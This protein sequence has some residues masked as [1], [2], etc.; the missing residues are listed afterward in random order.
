M[1]LLR[2]LIALS[3]IVV[4]MRTH[5]QEQTQLPMPEVPLTPEAAAFAKYGDVP[6]NHST[7]AVNFEVPIY[8]LRLKDFTVP[9]SLSYRSSGF[10]VDEMATDVGLGWTLQG[11]GLIS[12]S[13]RGFRDRYDGTSGY[14]TRDEI[15]ALLDAD[16]LTEMGNLYR[17]CE[18]GACS[19]QTMA[20]INQKPENQDAILL[21]SVD[22]EPDIFHFNFP[23]RNGTF[24]IDKNGDFITLEASRLHI[25]WTGNAFTVIDEVGI[26]YSFN[27]REVLKN[28]NTCNN[29]NVLDVDRG[30]EEDY[31]PNYYLTSICLPQGGCIYYEYQDYSYV[32]YNGITQTDYF[33]TSSQGSPK[34]ISTCYNEVT[35]EE[36]KK[37]SRIFTDQGIEVNFLYNALQ[38]KDLPPAGTSEGLPLVS[39]SLDEIVIKHRN[40][41]INRFSL[42]HNYTEG[43]ADTNGDITD[44]T[45]ISG[46][47]LSSSNKRLMLTSVQESGKKPYVF[48]YASDSEFGDK[49]LPS[50]FSFAKDFWGYYNGKHNNP[51]LVPEFN[52]YG[53]LIGDADRKVSYSHMEANMLRKIIYP[54]GG[55]T[56]LNYE[57]HQVKIQLNPDEGGCAWIIENRSVTLTSS[58]DQGPQ[59]ASFQ[60]T[61]ESFDIR[62]NYST[63]IPAIDGDHTEMIAPVH[64][65]PFSQCYLINQQNFTGP[66]FNDVISLPVGN[67]ELSLWTAGEIGGNGQPIEPVQTTITISWSERVLDCSN[68]EGP[69]SQHIFYGGVRLKAKADMPSESAAPE[70]GVYRSYK[71]LSPN[72]NNDIYTSGDEFPTNQPTFAYHLFDTYLPAYTA[73]GSPPCSS[74]PYFSAVADKYIHYY[75][76]GSES[77]FNLSFVNGSTVIYD[78]VDEIYGPTNSFGIILEE[79]TDPNDLQGR[80]DIFGKRSYFFTNYVNVKRGVTGIY[81]ED[82]YSWL[83]GALSSTKDY[84]FVPATGQFNLVKEVNNYYTLHSPRFGSDPLNNNEIWALKISRKYAPFIL[85]DNESLLAVCRSVVPGYSHAWYK[86]ESVWRTLD[87]VEEIV[88][89]EPFNADE[90]IKTESFNFYNSDYLQLSKTVKSIDDVTEV[91]NHSWYP[92][93]LTDQGGIYGVLFSRNMLHVPVYTANTVTSFRPAPGGLFTQ[94]EKFTAVS[95]YDYSQFGNDLRMV[96]AT[97]SELP[98]PTQVPSSGISISDLESVISPGAGITTLSY[99]DFGN[100]IQVIRNSGE[101]RAF[102]WDEDNINVIAQANFVTPDQLYYQGFESDGITG[103]AKSGDKY[104]SGGNYIIPTALPGG[105]LKMSYWYWL[106]NTWHY[107]GEMDY[108]ATINSPGSRLDEVR[109]YPEGVHMTTFNHQIGVGVIS[110]TDSNGITSYYTYDEANRLKSIS[111]NHRHALQLIDYNYAQN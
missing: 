37:L 52:V 42:G 5:A 90:Y 59:T 94:N 47:Y 55:H 6:I 107:S 79:N 87:R 28:D 43:L 106:N 109:V 111:D 33:K 51:N 65:E 97:V 61:P 66:A 35:I 13:I 21:G 26:Q 91:S 84:E 36:G 23:G 72:I 95:R 48:K 9:I 30:T 17:V 76:I 39:G 78:Q 16:N 81:S 22:A 71:Y 99:N 19:A 10:K 56:L 54:T 69:D 25:T 60:I 45:A 89:S 44:F 85:P 92:T 12:Q 15:I 58:G 40:D 96:S 102:L 50:T 62:A 77:R 38:R 64:G 29:A 98:S 103:M 34:G 4:S 18:N 100:V 41:T 110:I 57:P 49:K 80:N 63:N 2:T 68:V 20:N 105:N 46:A 27:A 8:T 74:D 108:N 67:H 70:T 75:S 104:H 32:Y 24:F 93:D 31:S 53:H 83:S 1:N 82:D 3:F 86:I 11:Y 14:A 7:G 88:Y 101:S 73:S